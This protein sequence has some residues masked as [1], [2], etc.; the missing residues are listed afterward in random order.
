MKF[1]D[2]KM[3]STD[4]KENRELLAQF[5]NEVFESTE[6]YFTAGGNAGLAV[7]ALMS[8]ALNLGFT[9]GTNNPLNLTIH[10]LNC[11]A[12]ELDNLSKAKMTSEP[13]NTSSEGS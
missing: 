2:N 12:V 7:Y 6:A 10:L 5:R 9:T 8:V 3:S 11:A 4:N 1:L 13:S